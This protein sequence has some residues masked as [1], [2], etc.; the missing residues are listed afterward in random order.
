MNDDGVIAEGTTTTSESV[1]LAH[2]IPRTPFFDFGLQTVPAFRPGRL[3]EP[4][5]RARF[6]SFSRNFG[7]LLLLSTKNSDREG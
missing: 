7:L 1:P 3:A 5:A 6:A 4:P 2:H